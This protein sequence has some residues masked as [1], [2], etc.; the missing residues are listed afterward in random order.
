MGKIALCF[1]TYENLTQ[2]KL[3]SHQFDN[4]KDK[5]NIYI[6]NKNNFTDNNIQKYC[7]KNRIETRY[8]HK[9]LINATLELFRE[10]YNNYENEYFILLSDKCI[11]LYNLDYIYKKIYQINNNIISCKIGE[12]IERYENLNDKNFFDK[13]KFSKQSQWLVLKRDSVKFF[14]ENDFTYLYNDNFYAVDEHYFI[15]LCIKYN[16]NFYNSD[17]TFTNWKD[18]SAE[19]YIN[20]TNNIIYDIINNTSC[21]FL[22]KISNQCTLPNYFDHLY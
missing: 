19:T 12:S 15:N 9:S 2:S 6:H 22:R 14:L 13:Q 16:I 18:G 1:L 4:N 20:L 8:A 11:P 10:C 3:W 17:I 21:L 5:F 7:I